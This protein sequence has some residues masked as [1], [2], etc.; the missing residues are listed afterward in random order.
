MRAYK[1]AMTPPHEPVMI[2]LDSGLQEET[3]RDR[4]KLAIP[5]YVPTAPPQGDMNAV[6]E[7]A[8]LLAAAERPVIIADKY[9]RT[10]DGVAS[11]VQ[12]AEILQAP[13]IDQ[14]GRMNFPNTHH[15]FQNSRGQALLKDAD[16]ILGL[17]LSDYWGTVN[18]YVDNGENDG[19][20]LQESHIKPNAKLISISSIV[21]NTKSNYQ[22][23][24][25]FQ[26]V[27]V[28]MAGDAQAT[29]PALIEAVKQALPANRAAN[30]EARGA[31]MKKAWGRGARTNAAGG[32]L[33]LGC[34]P[35]QH[36]A[37]DDGSLRAD[38]GSRLV[39]G[40]RR[41][42]TFVAGRAGF[43]RWTSTTTTL[44]GPGA[45]AL[46]TTRRHR[47]APLWP[48]ARMGAS[49]STSSPTAT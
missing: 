35:D 25:R 14:K 29:M 19:A 42:A 20:G 9:A 2:A 16:V 12:L 39:I 22:D 15:L 21:L 26:V 31:A 6:R 8:R 11:L 48:I 27:D 28:E 4:S 45:M 1:L 7:A 46:A 30:I 41:P 36:G 24:Q 33:R 13:V 44:A 23:F 32:V 47:S 18:G 10:A 38:Q 17:E 3:L 49:R 5:R 40:R 37:H 43:G 34:E